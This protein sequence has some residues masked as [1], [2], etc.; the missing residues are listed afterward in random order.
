[1]EDRTMETAVLE[2]ISSLVDLEGF[3]VV[4][5]KS[6]RAKKVR[7]LMMVAT[8]TAAPCPHCGAI[9]ADRHKCHERRVSDLPWGGWQTELL[10][11]LFQFRCGSCNKYFTP[12]YPGLATEGAHATERFL[13]RLAELSTHGDV[14]RAAMFLGIAE[15][16]AEGWYYEYL[17]RREK[18]PA[19]N[20]EPIRAMGI[21]E[22]SLKKDT[23]SS[24]AS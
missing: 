13:E 8:M 22:L 18:A 19:K 5:T 12:R 6:D 1:M 24:V 4:E 15:K 21:D 23:A 9:T 10:I 3:E 16:T 14:S 7:E 2:A 11:T 20:L 17:R